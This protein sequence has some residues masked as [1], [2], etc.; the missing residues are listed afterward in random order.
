MPKSF[1]DERY[2]RWSSIGE[3]FSSGRVPKAI[4]LRIWPSIKKHCKLLE[5]SYMALSDMNLIHS[6]TVNAFLGPLFV[7]K[8]KNLLTT[9][10]EYDS[11][12][13]SN[14]NNIVDGRTFGKCCSIF[15]D[16]VIVMREANDMVKPLGSSVV[17]VFNLLLELN[18][19]I[20]DYWISGDFNEGDVSS[21]TSLTI[22]DES[23]TV[24]QNPNLKQQRYFHIP[25]FG[26]QYCFLH[27]KKGHLRIHIFVDNTTKRVFVPYIGPHLST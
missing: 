22:T 10:I 5:G 21:K 14:A 27:I 13:R 6:Q 15:L 7:Y 3:F 19:Y 20:A 23:D 17:T 8:T 24:K 16:H 9:F 12:R 18:N 11:F 1:E 26:G 25:G 2:D 4:S